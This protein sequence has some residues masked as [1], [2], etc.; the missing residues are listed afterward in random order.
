MSNRKLPVSSVYYQ[1]NAEGHNCYENTSQRF[2]RP[3]ITE[4]PS[5]QCMR[6]A[7][8]C[9]NCQEKMF[10]LSMSMPPA[11]TQ[12]MMP[13]NPRGSPRVARVRTND[14]ITYYNNANNARGNYAERAE[15]RQN[16]YYA[17]GIIDWLKTKVEG[18]LKPLEQTATVTAPVAQRP[19]ERTTT[20]TAPVTAPVTQNAPKRPATNASSKPVKDASRNL[21]EETIENKLLTT[22][23]IITIDVVRLYRKFSDII[24]KV[25][26]P[27]T[28]VQEEGYGGVTYTRQISKENLLS[29]LDLNAKLTKRVFIDWYEKESMLEDLK[30]TYTADAVNLAIQTL[31]QR[32]MCY[33]DKAF[34]PKNMKVPEKDTKPELDGKPEKP[35]ERS[36]SCDICGNMPVCFGLS[37][38]NNLIHACNAIQY[39]LMDAKIDEGRILYELNNMTKSPDLPHH[40]NN[41]IDEYT[42]FSWQTRE[43]SANELIKKWELSRTAIKDITDK[44]GIDL[45]NKVIQDMKAGV[46]DFKNKVLKTIAEQRAELNKK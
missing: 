42:Q 43:M 38:A 40:K 39:H 14:D 23:N 10:V 37:N 26:S 5:R 22:T 30:K 28:E 32:I 2:Y 36:Q 18:A 6:S 19:P 3:V 45:T 21:Q 35:W 27:V 1:N 25:T 4:L 15:S 20:V 9:A 13:R 34:Y 46:S 16:I 8:P 41:T 44:Y 24:A 12:V 7:S 11:R 29:D 33:K 17:N 31:P